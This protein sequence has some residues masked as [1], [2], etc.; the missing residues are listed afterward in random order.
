MFIPIS[1]E[2]F[3]QRHLKSNPNENEADLRDAL[4]ETVKLKSDGGK[5]QH[6][7]RPVWAAGSAITGSD[8]CFTC[9]T[10]DADNSEDYEIDSVCF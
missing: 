8:G 5:C 7:G 1:L 6:C 3:V 2:E 9:I 10:G 4:A